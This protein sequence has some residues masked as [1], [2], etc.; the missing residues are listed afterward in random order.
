MPA[1]TGLHALFSMSR[2]SFGEGG[3]NSLNGQT[4]NGAWWGE[5]MFVK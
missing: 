5:N 2:H 3:L 1:R 4:G